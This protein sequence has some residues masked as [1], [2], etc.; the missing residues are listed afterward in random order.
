MFEPIIKP[1]LKKANCGPN[2]CV[3]PK[4]TKAKDDTKASGAKAK[5]TKAKSATTKTDAGTKGTK[6]KGVKK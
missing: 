1:T 6:A 5:D 4:E 3:K 2:I